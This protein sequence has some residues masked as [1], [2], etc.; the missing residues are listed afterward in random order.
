MK[1]SCSAHANLVSNLRV[2]SEY[3]LEKDIFFTRITLFDMANKNSHLLLTSKLDLYR[4]IN[5]HLWQ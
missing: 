5:V 3:H 1:L 4:I 2:I